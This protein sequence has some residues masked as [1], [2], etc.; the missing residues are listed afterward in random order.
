MRPTPYK[1]TLDGQ[2]V[3]TFKGGWTSHQEIAVRG[4]Y[5]LF[6]SG[7]VQEKEGLGEVEKEVAWNVNFTNSRLLVVRDEGEKVIDKLAYAIMAWT[8]RP[9]LVK[10]CE[11]RLSTTGRV[12]TGDR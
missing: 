8:T 10:R 5:I 12:A 1:I 9:S 4:N 2:L 6:F 7:P 11:V 3:W